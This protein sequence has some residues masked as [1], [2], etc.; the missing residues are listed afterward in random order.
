MVYIHGNIPK[1]LKNARA[2]VLEVSNNYELAFIC[3]FT[4]FISITVLL[5]EAVKAVIYIYSTACC[6]FIG[7]FRR[8]SE[9]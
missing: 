6:Y 7:L 5:T 4:A 8:G 3:G 2:Y 1:Q 9:Q